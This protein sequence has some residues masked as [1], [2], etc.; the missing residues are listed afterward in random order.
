MIELVRSRHCVGEA[1]YHIQLTPKYRHGVFRDEAVKKATLESFR[2]TAAKLKIVL[3][4]TGF[5]PD[6][7][8]LFI[9]ACKNW[10]VAQ[11]VQRLKG[12]SARQVR[13]A[14]PGLAQSHC[15]NAFWSAGY[16]YRSIGAT[17]TEA[18]DYYVNHS[19]SKHWVALDYDEYRHQ[20]EQ[21]TLTNF[22]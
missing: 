12:V 18:M 7:A 13:L 19:Q 17:T 9:G 6:H 16:F 3:H 14:H 15:T 11:I 20:K 10:S 1:N 8:H 4:G 2:A 5:G 21:T 22:N